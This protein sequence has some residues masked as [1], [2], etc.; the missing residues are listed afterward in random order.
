M[1]T[2][3]GDIYRYR[4]CEFCNTN[5]R[6]MQFAEVIVHPSE[7]STTHKGRKIKLNDP[8]IFINRIIESLASKGLI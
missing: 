5:Y 3:G 1:R 7:V 6:T 8:Q 2:I 4:K